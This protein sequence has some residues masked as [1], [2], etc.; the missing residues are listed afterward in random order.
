MIFHMFPLLSCYPPSLALSR[1]QLQI[2]LLDSIKTDVGIV[3]IN[4]SSLKCLSLSLEIFSVY[5]PLYVTQNLTRITYIYN[6][7]FYM[8][9]RSGPLFGPCCANLESTFTNYGTI[10]RVALV[11][12]HGLYSQLRKKNLL[13]TSCFRFTNIFSRMLT[14]PSGGSHFLNS[15]KLF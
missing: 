12:S 2:Y 9:I 6:I 10:F 5:T 4:V 7:N 14:C 13:L 11:S 8:I 15:T 1:C 3:V